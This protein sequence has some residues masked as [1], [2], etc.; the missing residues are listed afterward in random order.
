MLYLFMLKGK[1]WP[2]V[3]AT[4]LNTTV[5]LKKHSLF[6][7]RATTDIQIIKFSK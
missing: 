3:H 5:Q 4:D 1:L 7:L 6:A 2:A